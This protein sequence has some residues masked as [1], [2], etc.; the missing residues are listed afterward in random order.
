MKLQNL[1]SFMVVVC[2]FSSN[3]GDKVRNCVLHEYLQIQNT[4]VHQEYKENNLFC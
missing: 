2:C 3:F 1:V 4:C